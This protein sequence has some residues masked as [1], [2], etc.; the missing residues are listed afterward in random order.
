MGILW[1]TQLQPI[2]A[3]LFLIFSDTWHWLANTNSYLWCVLPTHSS[4]FHTLFG[5]HIVYWIPGCEE[6][7]GLQTLDL[8]KTAAIEVDWQKHRLLAA[9]EELNV[10]CVD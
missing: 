3:A 1:H 9:G 10:S 7:P 4:H 2:A 8:G 5:V 6:F